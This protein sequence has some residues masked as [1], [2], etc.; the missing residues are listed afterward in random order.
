MPMKKLLT[1]FALVSISVSVFSQTDPLDDL[2]KKI[3]TGNVAGLSAAFNATVELSLPGSEA[4]YSKPQAEMILRDFFAKNAPISMTVDHKGN[5]GGNSR[6]ANCT[7]DTQGG[8]YKV[9]ILI[10]GSVIFELRFD[11]L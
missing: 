2:L 8:R 5:S 9:Y 3:R 11:K 6:F 7:L 10:K 1:L 4:A